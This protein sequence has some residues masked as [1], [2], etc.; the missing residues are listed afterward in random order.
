MIFTCATFTPK[1]IERG[2][3]SKFGKVNYYDF[4]ITFIKSVAI[5]CPKEPLTLYLIDTPNAD[6][7]K[8]LHP[9]LEIIYRKKD[10]DVDLRRYAS[11]YCTVG[12]LEMI[13]KHDSVLC[14]DADIIVRKPIPELFEYPEDGRSYFSVMH[15][16]HSEQTK[17]KFNSGVIAANKTPNNTKLMEKWNYYTWEALKTTDAWFH[18]QRCLYKVWAS[19]KGLVELLTMEYAYNDWNFIEDSKIWHCK[20]HS[21]NEKWQKEFKK[22]HSMAVKELRNCGDYAGV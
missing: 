6:E 22:Y 5:N 3:E 8:V 15:R 11:C 17:N 16:P 1:W 13:K 21:D 14:L 19:N 20:G 10:L 12:F 2:S 7:L 9:K 4:L 18:D